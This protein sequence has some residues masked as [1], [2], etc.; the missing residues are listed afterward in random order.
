MVLVTAPVW[1]QA[2]LGVPPRDSTRCP[3]GHSIKGYA[4]KHARGEGIYYGPESPQYERVAPERCFASETE[5]RQ[6]GYRA[7]RDERLPA[8]DRRR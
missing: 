3:D 7:G 8:R 1:A 6:A 5:A 4:S 2:P